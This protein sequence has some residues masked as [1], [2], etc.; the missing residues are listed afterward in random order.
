MYRG[1]AL[2]HLKKPEETEKVCRTAVSCT[3]QTVLSTRISPTTLQQLDT[4][5]NPEVLPR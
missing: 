1:L 2:Q 5:G 3:D 4:Q